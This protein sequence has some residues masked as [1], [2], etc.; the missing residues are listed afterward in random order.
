MSS[1][2]S[3]ENVSESNASVV[4]NI[5]ATTF[6]VPVCTKLLTSCNLSVSTI[7]E[8]SIPEDGDSVDWLENHVL[9]TRWYETRGDPSN[10]FAGH[11]PEGPSTSTTSPSAD[12]NEYPAITVIAR[13]EPVRMIPN[14]VNTTEAMTTNGIFV[15]VANRESSMAGNILEFREALSS[16]LGSQAER[17]RDQETR[18][19]PLVYIQSEDRHELYL[20]GSVN[21]ESGFSGSSMI[22]LSEQLLDVFKM[23]FPVFK[24]PSI[25]SLHNLE[26]SVESKDTRELSGTV[27][28]GSNPRTEL[29]L[30]KTQQREVPFLDL[31]R[32]A[33]QARWQVHPGTEYGFVGWSIVWYGHREQRPITVRVPEVC[34]VPISIGKFRLRKNETGNRCLVMPGRV[35][36]LWQL[37]IPPTAMRARHIGTGLVVI[38]STAQSCEGVTSEISSM[39]ESE[40]PTVRNR[41]IGQDTMPQIFGTIVTVD[42]VL[43]KPICPNDDEPTIY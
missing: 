38:R 17:L 13:T 19:I 31:D 34:G 26:N 10:Y 11:D 28:L 15:N 6:F 39:S 21:G 22:G 40:Q 5:Q 25:P 18:T 30:G 12:T 33:T 36:E 24:H 1:E 23:S 42:R 3:S 37:R 4:N 35:F 20:Q 43:R 2:S 41:R 16:Q 27:G 14:S 8:Q 7:N 29:R 32:Q 9:E